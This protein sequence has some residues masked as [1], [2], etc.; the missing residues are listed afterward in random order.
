MDKRAK[1]TMHWLVREVV[2]S[3]ALGCP[4]RLGLMKIDLAG[5][6]ARALFLAPPAPP[7]WARR[8][9]GPR[10]PKKRANTT[11]GVVCGFVA[12]TGHLALGLAIG[13]HVIERILVFCPMRSMCSRSQFLPILATPVTAGIFG[14]ESDTLHM[15]QTLRPFQLCVLDYRCLGSTEC[16]PRARPAHAQRYLCIKN[17]ISSPRFILT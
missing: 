2:L 4:W 5:G 3:L 10:D 8:S 14:I 13:M 17:P 11:Q 16:L 7:Y 15:L 6:R 12:S 1:G 9:G